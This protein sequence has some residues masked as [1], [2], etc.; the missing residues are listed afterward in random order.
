MTEIY[1]APFSDSMVHMLH[2]D[3]VQSKKVFRDRTEAML[4][5][6]G[7]GPGPGPVLTLVALCLEQDN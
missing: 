3:Q 1:Q 5:W 4:D 2:M 7:P 6:I